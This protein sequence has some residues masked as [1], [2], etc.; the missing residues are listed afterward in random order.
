MKK[1]KRNYDAMTENCK[2]GNATNDK[3]PSGGKAPGK[4][5]SFSNYAGK[6]PKSKGI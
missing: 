6:K 5:W 4:A 2:K 3:R 1:G